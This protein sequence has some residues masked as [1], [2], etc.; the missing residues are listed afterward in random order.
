M[1]RII[2]KFYTFIYGDDNDRSYPDKVFLFYLT[3][4]ISTVI[5]FIIVKGILVNIPN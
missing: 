4:I 1:K 5:L 3:I 2:D